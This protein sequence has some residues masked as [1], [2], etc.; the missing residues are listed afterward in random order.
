MI[1]SG[2]IEI[3]ALSGHISA[4]TQSKAEHKPSNRNILVPAGSPALCIHLACGR[5]IKFA[6]RFSKKQPQ[7][8]ASHILMPACF[9]GP[10][11]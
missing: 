1:F 8:L 4:T 7:H 6:I 3:V 9:A 10:N 5:Y 2:R 11:F